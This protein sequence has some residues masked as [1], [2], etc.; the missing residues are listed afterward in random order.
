MN[1]VSES[2]LTSTHSCDSTDTKND[3]KY[4]NHKNNNL[5]QTN[6]SGYDT[7]TT[8]TN[9]QL[10]FSGTENSHSA[11]HLTTAVPTNE[12]FRSISLTQRIIVN[13]RAVS[14]APIL[15]QNKF[16][17]AAEKN[18]STVESF[19]RKQ[20]LIKTVY[21]YIDASFEIQSDQS[22][23]DLFECFGDKERN[24]LLIYYSIDP[25]W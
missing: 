20:L 8:I 2:I 1:A 24:E 6:T 9:Q 4:Y 5:N 21:C 3:V 23:Y 17:V 14:A 25:V 22:I 11:N 7:N 12:N 15:L 18:F 16:T 13:L 19:L 10:T